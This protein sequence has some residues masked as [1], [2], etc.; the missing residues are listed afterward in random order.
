MRLIAFSL[1]LLS[2]LASSLSTCV[3]RLLLLL[4]VRSVYRFLSFA[5]HF[6][7]SFPLVFFESTADIQ[8]GL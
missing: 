2:I 7:M 5:L 1:S 3:A 8:V 6:L 4:L